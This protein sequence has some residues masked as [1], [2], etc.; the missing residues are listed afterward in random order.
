MNDNHIIWKRR[1]ER[2]NKLPG[3]RNFRNENDGLSAV[4]TCL[5]HRF[6]INAG[7][8]A[9]GYAVQQKELFFSFFDY[10]KNDVKSRLLFLRQRRSIVR[11]VLVL[12]VA[13]A[14]Q[15]VFLQFYRAYVYKRLHHGA[16]K[17]LFQKRRRIYPS[18]GRC[19]E[20]Q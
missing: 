2:L 4:T 10:R 19:K 13:V 6:K 20:F 15:A 5:F 7:F 17:A 1:P 3:Q 18:P 11:M 8:P 9:A 14:E 16:G 12:S